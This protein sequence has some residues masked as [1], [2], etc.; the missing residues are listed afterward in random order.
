MAGIGAVGG[1]RIWAETMESDCPRCGEAAFVL[2]RSCPACGAARNLQTTAFTVAA[3]LALLLITVG[4]AAVTVLG[5]HQLAA[6]TETGD[7]LGEPVAAGAAHD[8][9][10]V[11]NAM[12]QCD[13][14]A[15]A[16]AD[17]LHF[18]VTPLV[19]VDGELASWRAKAINDSGNGI[20]LRSEDAF[21]GLR[22]GTLRL[23]AADYG[24][25]VLDAANNLIYRWRPSVGVVKFTAADPGEMPTFMVQFRTA[26]TGS[27]PVQG[28]AFNRQNGSCYWVN[29][30]MRE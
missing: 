3:A 19:A 20:M 7:A 16:D 17:T 28:G 8:P 27:E 6:A 25:G 5:W 23:Y 10:W 26:H 24:F 4:I 14:E 9:T 30:I 12:K 2:V 22:R 1:W 21:D 15:K 11:A 18:L 29:A 13:T